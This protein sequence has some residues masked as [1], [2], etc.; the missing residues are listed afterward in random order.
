MI[1]K[2]I[3]NTCEIIAFYCDSHQFFVLILRSKID[4][5]D[6]RGMLIGL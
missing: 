4:R 3:G 2:V 6:I 1:G 5:E